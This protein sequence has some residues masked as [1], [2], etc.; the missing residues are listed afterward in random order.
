MTA[1]N[2]TRWTGEWYGTGYQWI[3]RTW[4]REIFVGRSGLVSNLG[5][6]VKWGHLIYPD[7][8][9]PPRC[10]LWRRLWWCFDRCGAAW[11]RIAMANPTGEDSHKLKA[12]NSASRQN[13]NGKFPPERWSSPSKTGRMADS[14]HGRG[15]SGGEWNKDEFLPTKNE[16]PPTKSQ[17]STHPHQFP[18]LFHSISLPPHIQPHPNLQTT[19]PNIESTHPTLKPPLTERL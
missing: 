3:C 15:K 18:L 12:S 16:P 6:E 10:S 17:P 7:P 8:I 1:E 9:I 5:S 2:H 11:E 13:E 4:Y 14:K 19:I